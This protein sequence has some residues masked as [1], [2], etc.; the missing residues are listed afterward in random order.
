[1]TAAGRPLHAALRACARGVFPLEAGI[2]LLIGHDTWLHRADF[3]PGFVHTGA[4]A[5]PTAPP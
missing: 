4:P 3:N 5:S 1:M 2:E